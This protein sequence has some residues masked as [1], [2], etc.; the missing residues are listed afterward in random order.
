MSPSQSRWSLSL[1]KQFCISTISKTETLVVLFPEMGL[2][3]CTIF[4]WVPS[5]FLVGNL[6]QEMIKKYNFLYFLSYFVQLLLILTNQWAKKRNY[7]LNFPS[8]HQHFFFIKK[9]VWRWWVMSILLS[10]F[11]ILTFGWIS[12]TL[13]ILLTIITCSHGSLRGT[14][15]V[16]VKN[17]MMPVKRKR[18]DSDVVKI[19]TF[20]SRSVDWRWKASSTIGK[21]SSPN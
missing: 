19:H 17:K 7:L 11:L 4:R 14:V 18:S 1:W 2:L 6:S 8:Q 21:E 3:L 13:A 15:R 16:T 10:S 5:S 9:M 20:T 12:Q